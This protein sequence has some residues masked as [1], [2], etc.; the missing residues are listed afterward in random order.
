MSE[1]APDGGPLYRAA[2]D[3]RLTP[4]QVRLLVALS[5]HLTP[6]E[7]RAVKLSWAA[8][9]CRAKRRSTASGVL[10]ALVTAGYLERGP[11]ECLVGGQCYVTYRLAIPAIAEHRPTG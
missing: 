10:R 5:A 6:A 7:F 2:T 1:H 9:L 4:L 8:K 3:A 11:M